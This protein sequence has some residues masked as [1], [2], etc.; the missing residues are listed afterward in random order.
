MKPELI[1]SMKLIEALFHILCYVQTLDEYDMLKVSLVTLPSQSRCP[2]K[3]S[4]ALLHVSRSV[5]VTLRRFV[6]FCIK[7]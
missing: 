1:F 3:A 7:L 2:F 4:T 5:I 6:A